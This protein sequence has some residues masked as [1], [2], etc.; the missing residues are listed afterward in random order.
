MNLKC[1]LKPNCVIVGLFCCRL[2]KMPFLKKI[3]FLLKLSFVL[4]YAGF[5]IYPYNVATLIVTG[6]SLQASLAERA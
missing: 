5:G 2:K 3:N 6:F 4:V 1:V